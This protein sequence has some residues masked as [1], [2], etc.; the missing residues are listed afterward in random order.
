MKASELLRRYIEGERNFQGVKLRGE[1]LRG[2]NLSGADFSGADI[3]GADFTNA[4]LKGAKFCRVKTGLQQPR[5][6]I[7]AGVVIILLVLAAL[8]SSLRVVLG[9]ITILSIAIV[10]IAHSRTSTIRELVATINTVIGI[11]SAVSFFFILLFCIF[12][13]GSI[14]RVIVTTGLLPLLLVLIVGSLIS[15]RGSRAGVVSAAIAQVKHGLI[16]VI[17]AISN[18][19]IKMTVINLGGTS[20]RKADLTD[21]DFSQATIQ[22]TNFGYAVLRN[23]FWRDVRKFDQLRVGESYLANPKISQLIVTG[24]IQNQNFDYQNLRGVNLR[25]ADLQDASLIGANLKQANLQNADLSRAKLVQTQ[26]DEANLTGAMLTGAT[27]EDWGVTRHTKL[28]GVR[29]RYIFMRLPTKDDPN[30]RRKPDNW[31][32]EFEDGDFADFIQPIVD[33]L[34]LYHNQGVDPRAIAISLKRLAENH[35][36]AELEIVGMEKRGG[37]NLLLRLATALGANLSQLSAEYFQTYNEIKSLAEKEVKALLAEKDNRIYNLENMIVTA[38]QRPS[39]YTQTY[40]NKG[41][42]FM[43]DAPKKYTKN[44]FSGSFTGVFISI[45]KSQGNR[46]GGSIYANHVGG[47]INNYPPE[48]KQNLADAAAEIQQLLQQLEQNY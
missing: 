21:V 44:E 34:D 13:T 12:I 46:V 29:C 3:R 26:L 37:D 32:E 22:Y 31:Q 11:G 9:V 38:L 42:T 28:H 43:A 39:F 2:Q 40:Q 48:Q 10:F 4:N 41:D 18:E 47:I 35:P 16:P 23:V 20:F 15:I 17:L 25:A 33:T 45:D 6:T 14:S 27:I 24:K 8:S 5:F 30:P 7:Y 36:D 19:L 1:S